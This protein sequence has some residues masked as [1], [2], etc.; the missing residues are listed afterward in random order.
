MNALASRCAVRIRPTVT[1]SVASADFIS[2]PKCQ[3]ELH[4]VSLSALYG[5]HQQQPSADKTPQRTCAAAVPAFIDASEHEGPCN[6][7]IRC[8]YEGRLRVGVR[9]FATKRQR[10]DEYDSYEV[11]I[12]PQKV[13]HDFCRVP[14]HMQSAGELKDTVTV[15]GRMR[16]CNPNFWLRCSSAVRDLSECFRSREIVAILNAYAKA[17]YRDAS[18]F[19]HLGQ[20]LVLQAHDCRVSDLAVAVQAFARLNIPNS[21]FFDLLAVQCIR[22]INELGPRGVATVAAAY[23]GVKHPHLLLFGR[24]AQEVEAKAE[25]FCNIDLIQTLW[26]C[27]RVS[28]RHSKML[29]RC[30]DQ[31]I[32]RLSTCTVTEALTA[33]EAFAALS[34]YRVDLVGSLSSFFKC[35]I[36][37]LPVRSLPLLLQTFT[38][39]DRLAS[40]RADLPQ[41]RLS[42]LQEGNSELL[43]NSV[44]LY[45]AAL[46]V[47]ARAA[48]CFSMTELSAVDSALR[49]VGLSHDLLTRALQQELQQ[50]GPHLTPLECAQILRQV[51]SRGGDG[52]DAA[53]AAAVRALLSSPSILVSL[54]GMTFIQV[55]EDLKDLHCHGALAV[56][57]SYIYGDRCTAHDKGLLG[58]AELLVVQRILLQCFSTAGKAIHVLRT[59]S[60]KRALAGRRRNRQGHSSDVLSKKARML[61]DSIT[62][63]AEAVGAN[64]LIQAVCRYRS[65][66]GAGLWL[67]LL[68]KGLV[69]EADPELLPAL[70]MELARMQKERA[71]A[72][73]EDG[74]VP[75]DSSYPAA[76]EADPRLSRISSSA[77]LSDRFRRVARYLMESPAR[78]VAVHGVQVVPTSLHLDATNTRFLYECLSVT[79]ACSAANALRN[80]PQCEVAR[81]YVK[82]LCHLVCS[83]LQRAPTPEEAGESGMAC[84]AHLERQV[85]K[86]LA[87]LL[88]SL[89]ALR[90]DAPQALLQQLATR[91]RWMEGRDVLA[92]LRL[93]P[94]ST[95]A[96]LRQQVACAVDL[97]FRDLKSWRRLI[98][99]RDLCS[100]LKLEVDDDVAELEVDG[101][102]NQSAKGDEQGIPTIA[103]AVCD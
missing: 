74:S 42:A 98:E 73:E 68:M 3:L 84:S 83:R 2:S 63:S 30:A 11:T 44:A 40:P 25:A 13:P 91:L 24:L 57:A 9:G 35:R 46:P 56:I 51:A 65:D 80:H 69:T 5:L 60:E 8:P 19:G 55:L 99:L 31:I 77:Q 50:R 96:S 45:R 88:Q 64:A 58:G 79:A 12:D 39:F 49:S 47:I 103:E 102:G 59:E 62:A 17:G 87:R 61:Y 18:L 85:G 89:V 75:R 34:F 82:R 6:V 66:P 86:S 32:H 1:L 97:R 10:L 41:G 52:D 37:N 21:S 72:E 26:G 20:L 76:G 23:G 53:A 48:I 16:L 81:H 101:T 70:L 94:T 95:E 4:R 14:I 100:N 67:D 15:A 36:R 27:S 28:Y 22:K 33:A 92:V 93:F 54:P 90:A 7:R 29:H 71:A 38:T 78:G 43:T